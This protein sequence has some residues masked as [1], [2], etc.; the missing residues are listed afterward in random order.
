M[1]Q[2]LVEFVGSGFEGRDASLLILT[3]PSCPI[4]IRKRLLMSFM[5]NHC[6]DNMVSPWYL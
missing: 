4:M 1:L 6:Q 2:L 5:S 3:F